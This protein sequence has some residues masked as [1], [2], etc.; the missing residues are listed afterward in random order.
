MK[1][2]SPA[3]A[4]GSRWYSTNDLGIA[5]AAA[6]TEHRLMW[7]PVHGPAVTYRIEVAPEESPH[8]TPQDKPLPVKE[9]LPGTLLPDMTDDRLDAAAEAYGDVVQRNWGA[10]DQRAVRRLAVLAAV[11]RLR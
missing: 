7:E 8:R 5:V 3:T 4:G 2:D 10:D 9:E 11:E 1:G 6:L